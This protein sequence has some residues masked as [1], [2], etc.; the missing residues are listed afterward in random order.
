MGF[1]ACWP[2][3]GRLPELSWRRLSRCVARPLATLMLVCG[4][5][6]GCAAE[7]TAPENRPPTLRVKDRYYTWKEGESLLFDDSWDHEVINESDDIRVVLIVDFE[8]PVPWP[9]RA[10]SWLVLKL[11]ALAMSGRELAAVDDKVRARQA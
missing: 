9:L 6:V 2:L 4:P 3:R 8:R 5:W 10:Y 1:I 7:P 11:S